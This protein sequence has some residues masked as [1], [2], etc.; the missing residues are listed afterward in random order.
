MKSQLLAELTETIKVLTARLPAS[1]EKPENERL[2][3]SLEKQMSEYF[4][5][6]EMALPLTDLEALYYKRVK[7]E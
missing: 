3:K 7:Q 1:P 2:A 4:R 6:V 5:Q